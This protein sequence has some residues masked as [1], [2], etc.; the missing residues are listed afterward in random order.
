MTRA[1]TLTG[2]Y[3]RYVVVDHGGGYSTLYAHLN[4]IVATVGQVVD[5]GD[6]LGY[7]GGSGNVTGPHLHYEER[8]NGA[9]FPPYF[10]RALFPFGATPDLGQLQRPADRR[11]LGRR[12]R[13]P[14]S[15]STGPRPTGGVATSRRGTPGRSPVACGRPGTCRSSATSTATATHRSGSGGWAARPGA[16]RSASGKAVTVSGLGTRTDIPV[17][18]DWD[19]NGAATSACYRSSTHTFYLRCGQREPHRGPWGSDAA[20]SP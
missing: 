9:Y 20:T 4:Q 15:A 2:S 3:G 8:L 10:H 5:Q 19:G 1:V 18:G 13:R 17:T 16:L 12:R 6:L 11:R 14:T 7:V